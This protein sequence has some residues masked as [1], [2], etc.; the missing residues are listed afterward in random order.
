MGGFHL[1]YSPGMDGCATRSGFKFALGLADDPNTF[2]EWEL[3][4]IKIWVACDMM[5]GNLWFL[6]QQ[7]SP[8]GVRGAPKTPKKVTGEEFV[9]CHVEVM[10][11]PMGS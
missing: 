8:V 6:P 5:V 1:I 10:D 4:E 2:I 11:V 7:T 3:E 9:G